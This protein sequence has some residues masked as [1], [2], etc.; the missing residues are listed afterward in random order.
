METRLATGG[1]CVYSIGWTGV[2]S[3]ATFV[4]LPGIRP[5]STDQASEDAE[6]RTNARLAFSMDLQYE[7]DTYLP[8][9]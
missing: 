1:A 7:Y 2:V 3:G 9:S 4:T 5:K 6:P 8:S